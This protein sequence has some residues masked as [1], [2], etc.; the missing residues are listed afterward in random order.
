MKLAVIGS[1]SFNDY[2]KLKREINNLDFSNN[3][4]E[5]VSG[6]AR[7]ADSLAEKY[8]HEYRIKL[9]VFK[10]DWNIGKH[11]GFL[12]NSQIIEYADAVIAFWDGTSRGTLDSIKKT[13]K[14]GKPVVTILFNKGE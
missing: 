12:R 1:R 11:A 6:G 5:I 4:N 7:G 14:M 3:I 8:A 9:Q 13:E 10:P 2:E